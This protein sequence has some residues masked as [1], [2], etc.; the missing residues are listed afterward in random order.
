MARSRQNKAVLEQTVSSLLTKL[1]GDLLANFMSSLP[2]KN[3]SEFLTCIPWKDAE[4]WYEKLGAVGSPAK[5]NGL[6]TRFVSWLEGGAADIPNDL[7][8]K[9]EWASVVQGLKMKEDYLFSQPRFVD[10]CRILRDG[11]IAA[12]E[13]GASS[14]KDPWICMSW[15]LYKS[16]FTMMEE[17]VRGDKQFKND[18]L[19][20]IG[21]KGREGLKE[22]FAGV[23]SYPVIVGV[24]RG[25]PENAFYELTTFAESFHLSRKMKVANSENARAFNSL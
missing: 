21:D 1:D 10:F 24:A 3:L 9:G 11:S 17:K 13:A 22:I 7:A 18:V 19:S 25:L 4:P 8:S 23:C 6:E 15:D 12:K 20:S 2:K 14:S 16:L 5:N